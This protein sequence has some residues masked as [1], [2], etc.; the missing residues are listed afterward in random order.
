MVRSHAALSDLNNLVVLSLLSRPMRHVLF[1]TKGIYFPYMQNTTAFKTACRLDALN[2]QTNYVNPVH[3]TVMNLE[4]VVSKYALRANGCHPDAAKDM[5]NIFVLPM[6]V[7]TL[8]GNRR[9]DCCR[10]PAAIPANA[11][12]NE[13][14]VFHFH[15]SFRGL[16]ARVV[17]YMQ[18]QWHCPL[19]STL[20]ADEATAWRWHAECPPDDDELEHHRIVERTQNRSNWL[21][22][23][24]R[25]KA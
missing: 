7:N 22:C 6:H 23:G 20:V 9:L 11:R 19:Q 14:S 21:V 12:T 3:P 4:H 16:V 17:L 5:H 25:L 13:T 1:R 2:L 10:D 8:R 18:A 24:N 15:P